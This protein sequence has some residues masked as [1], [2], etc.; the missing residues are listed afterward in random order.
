MS[1]VTSLWLRKQLRM[2]NGT[3]A[4]VENVQNIGHVEQAEQFDIFDFCVSA[5]LL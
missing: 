3:K 1:G 5:D 2:L 4:L